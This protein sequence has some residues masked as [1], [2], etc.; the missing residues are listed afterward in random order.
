MVKTII[1]MRKY[2]ITI[3]FLVL[4]NAVFSQQYEV[5]KTEFYNSNGNLISS[6]IRNANEYYI[7]I[8]DDD[9]VSITTNGTDLIYYRLGLAIENSEGKAFIWKTL[10]ING[11][12]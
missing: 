12:L 1:V 9:E 3:F 6:T 8:I 5:Y 10:I 7:N 2:L 4:L 11:L